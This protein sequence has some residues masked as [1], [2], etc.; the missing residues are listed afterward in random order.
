MA[1]RRF[2]SQTC[3][4]CGFRFG[5]SFEGTN[6][7]PECG[8]DNYD[9]NAPF[10]HLVKETAATVFHFDTKSIRTLKALVFRPGFLTAEFVRGKRANY[11]KPVRFYI[12]I[13]FLFFLLLSLPTHKTYDI[14][15]ATELTQKK[16]GGFNI[17]FFSLSSSEMRGIRESQIDSVLQ[18][19]KLSVKPI[20]RYIVK[21]LIRIGS[22]GEKEF[23]H[24][25]IKGVSYMMF[26]LM[27]FIGLLVYFLYHRQQQYYIGA[28]IFSIHYHCFA[29]LALTFFVL[30]GKI[31]GFS[32]ILLITPL[33]LAVYLYFSL[34]TV[35]RQ[36]RLMTLNKTMLI[37]LLHVAS[38]LILFLL[39]VFI[40]LMVF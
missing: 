13:S 11:V 12:F 25:M 36:S 2:K 35:Y 24:L 4:N 19:R 29:F 14:N 20:N 22:G 18:S 16:S 31:P 27:P 38:V 26:I 37:G 5:T 6:F 21:Q 32:L 28:L 39:T 33:V 7:C 1:K 40:S 17:T 9:L 3:P 30:L 23:I 8:Q 10:R 34:R 15:E